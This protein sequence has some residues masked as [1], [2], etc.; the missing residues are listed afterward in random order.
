M[1]HRA[2]ALAAGKIF[3]LLCI[4]G[5]V[6]YA[7]AVSAR[8]MPTGDADA[9]DAGS[10]ALITAAVRGDLE[11]LRIM[12]ASD[13]HVNDRDEAGITPLMA[14]ARAGRANVVEYLL[15]RGADINAAAPAWGTPLMMASINGNTDVV[16]VLL[17]HGA[18]VNARPKK[19]LQR[20]AL[21]QAAS[22]GRADIVEML[23]NA[24]ARID[25]PGGRF[26]SPVTAAAH[27]ED[28]RVARLLRSRTAAS[29]NVA[30]ADGDVVP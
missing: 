14:A 10:H 30:S 6:G 9:P 5:S 16:R 27:S 18:D 22:T 23:L 21:W 13:A 29:Q 8:P 7:M 26:P 4:V 25:P 20:T 2:T 19:C 12:L 28:A 11:R 3:V 17:A 1:F 24:G 15:S